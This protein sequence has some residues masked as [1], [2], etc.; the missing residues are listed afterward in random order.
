MRLL[1]GL[2]SLRTGLKGRE[3]ERES[4]KEGKGKEGKG[5]DPQCLKCVDASADAPGQP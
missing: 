2:P 5:K 3:G 1:A 4:G